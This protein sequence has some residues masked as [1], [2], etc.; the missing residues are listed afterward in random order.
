MLAERGRR[1]KKTTP[2]NPI[3]GRARPVRKRTYLGAQH[4]RTVAQKRPTGLCSV[5]AA[6][7]LQ[8]I[9]RGLRF[10][11]RL[12]PFRTREA[13][14]DRRG[15]AGSTRAAIIAPESRWFQLRR[16]GCEQAASLRSRLK[17]C[18]GRSVL[19]PC[20]TGAIAQLGARLHGMQKVR[21]STPLGS[22]P[23]RPPTNVGAAPVQKSTKAGNAYV[24]AFAGSESPSDSGVR[25]ILRVLKM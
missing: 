7:K 8:Q 5:R 19:K 24:R 9:G 1:A 4:H 6:R 13:A 22:I 2:R 23:A 20:L 11:S 25:S 14:P 21:G 10:F 15:V 12:T 3:M 17:S 18:E 16:A